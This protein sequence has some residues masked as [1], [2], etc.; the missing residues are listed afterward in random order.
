MRRNTWVAGGL[1]VAIAGMVGLSF[2]SVPLYRLFC[3]ATG[4]AGT[5]QIGGADGPGAAGGTIVVRFDANT[6]P[7]IPWK[8]SPGQPQVTAKLG[9]E[10]LAYYVGRNDGDRAVTGVATTT[11]IPRKSATT[12]TR[13]PASASTSRPSPPANRKCNS[14][15]ASGSTRPSPPTRRL[16]TS[17]PSHC[18]THSSAPSTTPPVM[19]VCFTRARMS[20]RAPMRVWA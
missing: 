16:G 6:S 11:S 20:A 13:P 1:T 7:S 10:N 2:A 9:E 3:A 14:R 19:A 12:S 4:Y 5:P 8:F 15:S 17:T 18:P